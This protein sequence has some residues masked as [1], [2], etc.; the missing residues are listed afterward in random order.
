VK[1]PA[2]APLEVALEFGPDVHIPVGRLALTRGRVAFE[3]A[4][5]FA[6]TQLELSPFFDPPSTPGLILPKNARVF[7]GLSGVFAHSLPDAWGTML[8]RRRAERS[9]IPFAS[10]TV[11]DQLAIVGSRGPGALI[12]TPEIVS[13][14]SIA[15]DLD[16]LAASAVELL[17][18]KDIVAIEQLERLGGS[19]GGARPKVLVG[20]NM[21]GD[22][23][24]GDSRLPDGF[25][26]WIIKFR[27]SAH[28][29]ED[30]GALEAAYA[31]MARAAGVPMSET[32]LID[33]RRGR[34]FAT[35]RFD[36][37]NGN[38][39]LHMLSAAA[40]L[41]VPWDQPT[42]GYD[43]L[44]KLSRRVTR[45]EAAVDEMFR[46]MVFNVLS[47]NRDDH[48]N[49]HAYLMDEHG[50]WVLAPAFDLTYSRG[51]GGEHY[52]DVM[53]RGGDDIT[54]ASL[55]DAAKAQGI[56]SGQ[57]TR[58]IDD[59]RAAVNDFQQFAR[60]YDVTASTLNTVHADL[61]RGLARFASGPLAR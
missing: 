43:A 44:M 20:M 56:K 5:E 7:D 49:Q 50:Q 61:Q 11:L 46:R 27:S 15:V 29:I 22:L 34:Y 57:A 55:E 52:M 17:A 32:R 39:R 9:G 36:R 47:H 60:A 14:D 59:V 31:D 41:E 37:L 45:S 23:L 12:Y 24:P 35:K 19:S 48:A 6:Q 1:L 28:D 58:V 33:G 4:P 40:L 38:Q 10:L 8:V 53:G 25:S 30:I 21:A 51:P 26:H 16:A 18:G 13:D 3:Y 2:G 54:R 42:M